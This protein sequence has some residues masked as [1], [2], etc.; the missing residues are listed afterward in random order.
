MFI[1]QVWTRRRRPAK[2]RRRHRHRWEIAARRRRQWLWARCALLYEESKTIWRWR[3]GWG[4]FSHEDNGSRI[5]WRDLL[6]ASTPYFIFRSWLI[7]I[8]CLLV[9]NLVTTLICFHPVPSI[10]LRFRWKKI[11]TILLTYSSSW[12]FCRIS[13]SAHQST[14]L[15]S[16]WC[17]GSSVPLSNDREA[18]WWLGFNA[19]AQCYMHF[20]LGH[21]LDSL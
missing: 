15:P 9:I 21:C 11:A 7:R 14:E 17:R 5:G 19:F 4:W 13:D 2:A 8:C 12:F 10:L 18:F 16:S 6:L 3:G 1:L 20:L